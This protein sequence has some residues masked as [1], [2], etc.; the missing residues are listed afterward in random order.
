MPA[1]HRT[2]TT[3][4]SRG[5]SCSRRSC[6]KRCRLCRRP[7]PRHAGTRCS[8]RRIPA[9]LRRVR[10]AK[11]RR[12]RSGASAAPRQA[13]SSF[14]TADEAAPAA[15][16]TSLSDALSEALGLKPGAALT[17]L[18][19]SQVSFATAHGARRCSPPPPWAI[20]RPRHGHAA[21]PP[22]STPRNCTACPPRP[23]PARSPTP[24]AAST[25]AAGSCRERGLGR[26]RRRGRLCRAAQQGGAA[27]RA[28]G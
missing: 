9:Q 7:T 5:L 15:R 26:R 17:A 2:W 1:R 27:A 23:T 18:G 16:A 13:S 20:P 11:E 8:P 14:E 19:R 12:A 25:H 4:T 10:A 28:A 6:S 22:C 24:C 3:W 21:A